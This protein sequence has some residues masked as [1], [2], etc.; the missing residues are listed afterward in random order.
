[1]HRKQQKPLPRLFYNCMRVER[2]FNNVYRGKSARHDGKQLLRFQ[3]DD[4]ASKMLM[5]VIF[6]TNLS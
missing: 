5:G 3:D 4:C 2:L 6:A 1:M